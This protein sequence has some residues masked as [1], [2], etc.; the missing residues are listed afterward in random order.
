MGSFRAVLSVAAW[1]QIPMASALWIALAA[2]VYF[3]A[4]A[5][6]DVLET[7]LA[8]DEACS[9]AEDGDACAFHALQVRSSKG[10]SRDAHVSLAE[11]SF[12]PFGSADTGLQHPLYCASKVPVP[13][14]ILIPQDPNCADGKK[15]CK[16]ESYCSTVLAANQGW[17]P[18]CC[19]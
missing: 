9:K 6:M 1:M 13:P 5:D 4:T 19:S 18:N 10:T 3:S 2:G 16:C 12:W 11:E 8:S 14:G 17:D 15:T 7:A